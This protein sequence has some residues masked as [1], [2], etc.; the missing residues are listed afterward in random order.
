MR[1]NFTQNSTPQSPGFKTGVSCRAQRADVIPWV[2]RAGQETILL[3]FLLLTLG[4][5]QAEILGASAARQ[6]RPVGGSDFPELYQWSDVANSY[7]IRRGESALLIDLGDGSSIDHL[8]EIGVK[9]IEWVLFTHHHRE[10]TQ[11]FNRLQ[12]WNPKVAGPEAERAL[13][14][15]P[16]AF[17]KL[18]PKL[19]D[20]F[21]V[22]G[23]SYVRPGVRAIKLDQSFARMDTF[24]W[25]DLEFWCVD[26]RG[27]SPGS[28]SY[29]LRV[30]DRWFAFSGDVMLAN[31]R[32]H[33][34]FD[35]EWDYSFAS[36]IY[37]LHN[38]A[39]LLENFDPSLLLPSHG[40]VIPTP[41]KQ[42]R[43]Y[44][45]KLRRLEQLVVRGY[46]VNTY[47]AADQD[48]VSKPTV[49]PF[50]W[51]VTPHLYKF[52]G[53]NFFPNFNL[54]LSDNGRGLLVDC[55]LFDEKFLDRSIELMRE[56][57]GLKQIDA[58]L[59][60]HMHGD[61]FLEAP[62]LRRRWGAQIW[63]LDRMVDQIERP[64]R[65]DYVAPIQAYGKGIES[66]KID[67]V[68]APGETFQWEGYTMT[69]DWM[70]GQTEFAMCLQG[71]IDGRKVA[72]TGDNIFANAR[73]AKQ[74]GHEAIVA[75][76]SGIL[77]EGYIYGAEYLSKL[78]P[79]LIL[80]GH[81][82][83]MDRPAGLIKRYRKWAYEMR[84]AFQALSTDPEYRYWFGPY[85][86]RAEPYR[87]AI[88]R[89]QSAEFTLH[90]RNFRSRIQQHRIE[91]HPPEGIVLPH[92]VL[93]GTV[94]AESRASFKVQMIAAPNAPLGVAI[95]AFDIT[96]D[97][98]RY[99]EWFDVI[100][101]IQ[102]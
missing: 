40:P 101:D 18:K 68:F 38:S 86:V 46:E 55:G 53:P 37:A 39:A 58:V 87:V 75:R 69:V 16:A 98:H 22:H 80:G 28:M 67:R 30:R 29:L 49:V 94:P 21:T 57:L 36:G 15:N 33:N 64:E 99:G 51:Q 70:P 6:W 88:Q 3:L 73:D 95:G 59:I 50:L 26:T 52:K 60:S 47:A 4:M 19:N 27:N 24:R 89:G 96:L 25:K 12:K 41:K 84:A 76:N 48:D 92:P 56:R 81:S 71:T 35:T 14:E 82:Y 97:S 32:M 90:I 63:A 5:A 42:L 17:R 23:T 8:A 44:Q 54:I 62:H 91:L 31:A 78:K 7:L 34:W 72:F 74:S 9:Q 1:L 10:Q 61:H 77:E 79:D 102:E 85:W 66:V 83:V 20:S 43:D 100:I 13:F 65:Y 11:G 93:E 45:K 2:L